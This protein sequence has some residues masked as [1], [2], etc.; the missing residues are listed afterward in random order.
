MA[1]EMNAEGINGV[2]QTTFLVVNTGGGGWILPPPT[3]NGSVLLFISAIEGEPFPDL[4]ALQCLG[5][6]KGA[7]VIAQSSGGAFG[8]TGPGVGV[9]GFNV[10]G[11]NRN[12]P[13]FTFNRSTEVTAGVFGECDGGPG[14]MG[15]GGDAI[16]PPNDFPNNSPVDAGF[17]V[18][19]LGGKGAAA[20]TETIESGVV[21]FPALPAGAGVVGVAGGAS[22]PNPAFAEGTG[23]VG[24]GSPAAH[25]FDPGRGGVFGS[26]GN[27][28]QAQLIPA[29]GGRTTLPTAGR[30]GDLY[31]ILVNNLTTL[32]LCVS[33]S[34]PHTTPVTV[35]QWAPFILGA[36]QSGGHAP[37]APPIYP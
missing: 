29:P 8:D 6:G 28:A 2:Q 12:N 14:V 30:F 31:A 27:M 5:T 9:A 16:N 13:T 17:G 37:V 11:L 34:D 20:S 25:G 3:S 32:F 21:K 4:A 35:A 18:I 22:M 10:T 7:G 36:T 1:Y 15:Q 26:A 19:G 23:V 33:P 24:I